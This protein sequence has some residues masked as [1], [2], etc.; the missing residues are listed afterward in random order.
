MKC[1]YILYK[2]LEEECNPDDYFNWIREELIPS[3]REY[4]EDLAEETE[5]WV[6]CTSGFLRRYMKF[7]SGCMTDAELYRLYSDV[8]KM[9]NEGIQAREYQK[10]LADDQLNEAR[11]LYAQEIINEDEFIDIKHSVKEVKRALDEDIEQLEELKDF[12]IRA[13]DKFD[14]VMCIERVATTAHNRGVML[15]VM[16]GAYLPE[17]IID[18]VTGWEREREYTRPE[19]VGLWLSRDVVKVFE[20]IKEFKE[21]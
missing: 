4:S 5:E 10:S 6:D 12:C 11:E 16:C 15:P 14:V 2:S 8:L 19:D 18:A 21:M 1:D 13:E 20:C 3:I 9:I 17:D 7:A